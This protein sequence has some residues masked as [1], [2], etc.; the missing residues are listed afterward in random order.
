MRL[1]E[2]KITV[3]DI[4]LFNKQTSEC[5]GFIDKGEE[6]VFGM[7]YNLNIRPKF[8][9]EFIYE[10]KGIEKVIETVRDGLPLGLI[11]FV[12]TKEGKY[13]ILDGQQRI[14][15]LCKY[16]DGNS[17]IS[18]EW[19]E[20]GRVYFD[21]LSDEEMNKLIDYPLSVCICE[22]TDSEILE[23]FFR[24]N[25][26]GKD[27]TAQEG[28]NAIFAGSWVSDARMYFSKTAC[29]AATLADKYMKGSPIRQD[30]LETVIKWIS[31]D[32][33]QSYMASHQHNQDAKNLWEYF[34]LVIDWVQT[35]FTTYR[36]EMKGVEWGV[37]YNK[38]K[39]ELYDPSAIE[40]KL[41]QLMEDEQVGS[42]KGIYTY[43]FTGDERVLNLR[44]FS[45][46]QKRETYEKQEGVCHL[47]KEH[48]EI[49]YME[50]DHITPWA[51]DG[52][53]ISDNCQMLCKECNRRKGSK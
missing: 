44:T 53:T 10:Q 1:D 38:Y 29:P 34:N 5:D 49:E 9:R 40:S 13:E 15:S 48:F 45:D 11:Y 12:K 28:R 4:V 20:K 32:Q 43:I 25:I 7:N 17:D 19:P 27:L 22:G 46:K 37:L 31:E 42:K 50:A 6:G 21:N 36:N 47:C 16:I 26:H 24:I 8:Q 23:W 3:N 35:I 14:L 30:Y 33:I 39:G 18:A 2:V 52:K 41:K 51:D